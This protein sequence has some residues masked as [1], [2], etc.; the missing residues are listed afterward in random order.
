LIVVVDTNVWISALQ[1]PR[2]DATPSRALARAKRVDVIATCDEIDSE[3]FKTLTS[4]FGWPSHEAKRAIEQN[5]LRAIRVAISGTMKLCRDS[6]DDMLLE[7]AETAGADL[8]I[9]GDKDLLVLGSYKCLPI[10]TA[11]EYLSL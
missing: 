8:L 7:C 9:T 2:P 3:V 5:L 4:K 6:H 10:V 11:A 1:F